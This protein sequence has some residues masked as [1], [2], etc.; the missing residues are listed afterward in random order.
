M[1]NVYDRTKKSCTFLGLC[2][3][4][5]ISLTTAFLMSCTSAKEPEENGHSLVFPDMVLRQFKCT[6]NCGRDDAAQ[7]YEKSLDKWRIATMI[8][9]AKKEIVLGQFL[10]ISVDNIVA[11]LLAA[12]E[13]GVVVKIFA[14]FRNLTQNPAPPAVKDL[15]ASEEFQKG[16]I[17]TR[18]KLLIRSNHYA[19]LNKFYVLASILNNSGS[20]SRVEFNDQDSDVLFHSKFLLVDET[21]LAVQSGNFSYSGFGISYEMFAYYD[22]A[23]SPTKVNPFVC[24]SKLLF[25]D[26]LKVDKCS[27]DEVLFV[28]PGTDK[29]FDYVKSIFKGAKKRIWLSGNQFGTELFPDTIEDTSIR[30]VDFKVLTG[31]NVCADHPRL[32]DYDA[33]GLNIRCVPVNYCSYQQ[34]HNKYFIADDAL[35]YGTLNLDYDGMFSGWD[36]L[37]RDDQ[38]IGKVEEH[39]SDLWKISSNFSKVYCNNDADCLKRHCVQRDLK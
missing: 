21:Y 9:R 12:A 8:T 19:D 17:A 3:F 29:A 5:L 33:K 1:M 2:S 39:F 7:L 35:Y 13:K 6:P 16:N 31:S 15:V 22:K 26:P 10:Y 11:R 27:T 18:R 23:K 4:L 32:P 38:F 36:F 34:F 14:D 20:N 25:T 28:V 24:A 37:I 30:G